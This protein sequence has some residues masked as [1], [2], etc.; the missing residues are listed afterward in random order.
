MVCGKLLWVVWCRCLI[1]LGFM[2]SSVL[3]GR[4]VGDVLLLCWMV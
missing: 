3:L 2:G 1:S 4:W